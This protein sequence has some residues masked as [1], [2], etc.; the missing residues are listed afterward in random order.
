M[1]VVG[2]TK[3]K[4]I[5]L[6]TA[7]LGGM[8]FGIFKFF[9][10]LNI[11]SLPYMDVA[12]QWAEEGGYTHVA[13]Y[14][15]P[16]AFADAEDLRYLHYKID[17]KLNQE[18][19]EV[20]KEAHPSAR[21]T[22]SSFTANGSITVSSPYANNVTLGA[23]GVWGDFFL[24]HDQELLDGGYFSD[25]DLNDDYCIVDEQAA[26]KLFG[27]NEISG[28]VLYVGDTPL[29]IRGVFRQPEDKLS[30]AAGAEGMFCYISYDFLANHGMINNISC[31]EIVMPNP[32]PNYAVQKL[33]KELGMEEGKVEYVD[34]E[35]RFDVIES[36]KNLSGITQ[37]GMRTKALVYPWWENVTRVK[38][39]K[40]SVLNLISVIGLG[41]AA[42][43]VLVLIVTLFI[44]NK[45]V[46]AYWFVYLYE[47]IR[48]SIYRKMQKK[49]ALKAEA[50]GKPKKAK[51][52][53]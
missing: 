25:S 31:Y 42:L 9:A 45:D 27:S 19:I 10:Y 43:V 47:M 46:I 52:A 2:L 21:L 1:K 13:A 37:R 26:W 14:F 15:T 48:D 28:K 53:K 11:S 12:K 36:I 30:K 29:V 32:V 20:D 38:A 6:C 18:S 4:L 17:E 5:V 40:I 3:Y 44:Q 41:Y 34:N 39:D 51:N 50:S 49:R 22:A 24:F 23:M 8:I 7:V 16:D 35:G 33:D